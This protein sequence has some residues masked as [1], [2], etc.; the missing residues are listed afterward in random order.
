MPISIKNIFNIY[1][2]KK[3]YI[4]AIF[5]VSVF[6]GDIDRLSFYFSSLAMFLYYS[7][8]LL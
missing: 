3:Y 5:Y 1:K 6:K 2:L 8:F 7:L 4:A